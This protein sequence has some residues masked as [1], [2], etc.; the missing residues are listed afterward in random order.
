MSGSPEAGDKVTKAR[1]LKLAG[2]RRPLAAKKLADA[3]KKQL[4]VLLKAEGLTVAKSAKDEEWKDS[5]ELVDVVDGKSVVYQL[6]VWP[7]GNGVMY[8]AGK[9]KVIANIMQ[10][11]FEC[12]DAEL[13]KAIAA[14]WK[15]GA[16]KL[17][18]QETIDEFESPQ[19]VEAAAATGSIVEQLQAFAATKAQLNMGE[20]VDIATALFDLKKKLFPSKT[21]APYPR[22]RPSS[23]TAEQRAFIETACGLGA[24]VYDLVHQGLFDIIAGDSLLLRMMGKAPQGPSDVEI[25][26]GK[27]KLPLWIAVADVASGHMEHK[28][29]IDA[30]KKLPV[31]DGLA[32]WNEIAHNKSYDVLYPRDVTP[33][34]YGR[35]NTPAKMDYRARVY[36]WLADA[37]VALGDPGKQAAQE[38]LA[39]RLDWDWGVRWLIG[40]LAL[41]RHGGFD[42]QYDERIIPIRDNGDVV[43]SRT[44]FAQATIDEIIKSLPADRRAALPPAPKRRK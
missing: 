21:R 18:I 23:L 17:K 37:S 3:E 27:E 20:R 39:V 42:S 15:T 35:D 16:K 8:A 1:N 4:S 34:E 33:K 6:Y 41:S 44:G 19:V 12:E 10:H 31:E 40:L 11:T 7:S 26:V 24:D 36:S 2:Y 9:T 43:C 13:C 5:V 28:A 29:V 25:T 14:A 30:F 32:A 38:L 22:A